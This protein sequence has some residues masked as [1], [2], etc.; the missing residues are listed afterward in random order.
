MEK[1][2]EST[3]KVTE[4]ISE[5]VSV[6]MSEKTSDHISGFCD[7]PKKLSRVLPSN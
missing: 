6:K 7:C 4:I 5:E 2:G 3:V 1:F